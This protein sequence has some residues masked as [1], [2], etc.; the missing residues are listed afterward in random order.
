MEKFNYPWFLKLQSSLAIYYEYVR[1]LNAIATEKRAT[2]KQR[3]SDIQFLLVY[4]SEALN[5]AEQNFLDVTQFN[6]NACFK[7]VDVRVEFNALG[8]PFAYFNN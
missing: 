4:F 2:P 6:S 7:A 1:R 8:L 5:E 3:I